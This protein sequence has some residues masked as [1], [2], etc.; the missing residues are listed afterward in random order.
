MNENN[1]ILS[2]LFEKYMGYLDLCSFPQ[3]ILDV[4]RGKKMELLSKVS[5]VKI[6]RKFLEFVPIIPFK[7]INLRDQIKKVRG[8]SGS[9]IEENLFDIAENL[10]D[11]PYFI[12]GVE[13][14]MYTKGTPPQI[15]EL[16]IERVKR[17]PLTLA[18]GMG[19]IFYYPEILRNC[20]LDCIGTRYEK[21][22]KIP[23]I[24]LREGKIRLGLGGEKLFSSQ[25][26]S[27]SCFGRV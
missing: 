21:R 27:P 18:E 16:L 8:S 7:I 14:G 25:W 1:D 26:G 23:H 19:V 5:E 13:I 10:P 12:Y 11:E 24:L 4:F 17:S 6:P 15:A 3:E 22:N 9:L 20:Y 2:E